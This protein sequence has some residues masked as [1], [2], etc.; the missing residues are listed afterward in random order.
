MRYDTLTNSSKT[1]WILCKNIFAI[2]VIYFIIIL[3]LCT[4][5]LDHFQIQKTSMKII[6]TEEESKYPLILFC[7]TLCMCV[8]KIRIWS[9]LFLNILNCTSAIY[10]HNHNHKFYYSSHLIQQYFP[11]FSSSQN[12][13]IERGEEKWRG[14]HAS[15]YIAEKKKRHTSL[16]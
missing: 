5:V 12:V 16:C 15:V 10:P 6:L 7:V 9:F 13:Y 2:K 1:Y 11:Y 4:D 8:Q 14:M 3:I